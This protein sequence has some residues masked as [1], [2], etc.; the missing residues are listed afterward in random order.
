VVRCDRKV[1]QQ[2][3]IAKML[4]LSAMQLMKPNVLVSKVITSTTRKS[5]AVKNKT[6]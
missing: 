1:V 3:A 5:K 6:F 4:G 2:V